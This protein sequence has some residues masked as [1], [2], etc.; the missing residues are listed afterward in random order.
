MHVELIGWSSAC[1]RQR[2]SLVSSGVDDRSTGACQGRMRTS[3]SKAHWLEL[4]P[5]EA[6]LGRPV[7]WM[8]L[9]VPDKRRAHRQLS[10][11]SFLA[12]SS[13]STLWVRLTLIDDDFTLPNETNSSNLPRFLKIDCTKSS[14]SLYARSVSIEHSAENLKD[15]LFCLNCALISAVLMKSFACFS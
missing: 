4:G 14:A 10:R 13:G 3:G 8:K 15:V 1:V 9:P 2:I 12:V 11:C 6:H 5:C 7:S